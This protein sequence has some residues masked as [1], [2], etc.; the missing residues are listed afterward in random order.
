MGCLNVSRFDLAFRIFAATNDPQ[1]GSYGEFNII[2][3]YAWYHERDQYDWHIQAVQASSGT[4]TDGTWNRPAP[5][6]AT[7]ARGLNPH[8]ISY[9]VRQ[10]YCFSCLALGNCL[11]A[12]AVPFIASPAK[13]KHYAMFNWEH[14]GHEWVERKL[15]DAGHPVHLQKVHYAHVAALRY[16]WPPDIAR[17]INLNATF[18][19]DC[20]KPPD[21]TG[22]REYNLRIHLKGLE[23]R[24]F[25]Q[26][27]H[28]QTR[29]R[30]LCGA[31]TGRLPLT[32]ALKAR[33]QRPVIN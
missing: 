5:R 14:T 10:G 8:N 3:N 21:R 9:Y 12:E 28:G 4:F 1:T 32:E 6:I 18:F 30:E 19:P 2:L 27:E 20:S 31:L 29:T 15:G 16:R 17:L 7:H 33:L 22:C 23:R 24:K 11:V 13:L 25:W 26:W